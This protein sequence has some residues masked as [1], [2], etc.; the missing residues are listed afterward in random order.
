MDRDM[1]PTYSITDVGFSDKES[2]F[3]GRESL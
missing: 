1:I 3:T 2:N